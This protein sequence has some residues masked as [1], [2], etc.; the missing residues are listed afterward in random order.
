M[1]VVAISDIHNRQKDINLPSGD[2][3]AIAGDWT[4][5]GT[6]KEVT[7][8]GGWLHKIQN[9]FRHIVLVAG[10]HDELAATQPLLL[11]GILPRS[12]HYLRDTTAQIEGKIIHGSPWSPVYGRWDFMAELPEREQYLSL[13]PA[14]CDLLISHGPA[15]GILDRTSSGELAGCSVLRGSLEEKTIKNLICG[16]IHEGHGR[17]VYGNTNCY[18]VSVLDENYNLVNQPTVFDI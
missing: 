12:V 2:M 7:A 15:L 13:I 10:N 8:F 18:N 1:R 11:A 5:G 16:H 3:L 14:Y 4:S 9:Q 17:V 6:L